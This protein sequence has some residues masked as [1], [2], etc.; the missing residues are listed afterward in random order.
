MAY[1]GVWRK[2]AKETVP[3]SARLWVSMATL[4]KAVCCLNYTVRAVRSNRNTIQHL[5]KAVEVYSSQTPPKSLVHD[6]TTI[7]SS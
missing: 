6:S 3:S 2:A 7:P 5:R 1:R 4:C